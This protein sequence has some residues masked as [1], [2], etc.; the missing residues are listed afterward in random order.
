LA[1]YR[2]QEQAASRPVALHEPERWLYSRQAW[3]F[4]SQRPLALLLEPW[5]VRERSFR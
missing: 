3:R 1:R 2:Y 5:S 4:M